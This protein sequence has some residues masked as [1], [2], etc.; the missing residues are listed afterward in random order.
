MST[1][2]HEAEHIKQHILKYYKREDKGEVSAY[3]IGYI[4]SK[5]YSVFV[6]HIC[7]CRI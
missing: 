6:N 5:M 2:V 3:L 7:N 1:I 4:I